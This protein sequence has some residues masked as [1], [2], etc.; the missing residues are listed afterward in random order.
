MQ[1]AFLV[2]WGTVLIGALLW[3]LAGPGEFALRDMVVLHDPYLTHSS[4]GFGDLPGRNVPQDAVLALLPPPATWT[5]RIMLIVS[6]AV[7]AFAA[8]RLAGPHVVAQAAAMTISVANPFVI[9]RLL[10]GHWSLVMAAWLL[11]AIAAAGQSKRTGW[12][13]IALWGASLTPTGGLAATATAFVTNRRPIVA[14]AGAVSC[15]PWI[16]TGMLHPDAGRSA[17][18]SAEAFAPRAEGLV[19]TLGALLGLG[20]LWNGDAVPP[21]RDAGFAIFGVVLFALLATAYRRIPASFLL[22]AA[23]GFGI[24]VFSWLAPGAMGWLIEHVP[25]AG[26]LRDGQ[27]WVMLAIPAYVAAA[28]ALSRRW[29]AIALVLAFLQTPDAPRAMSVLSPVEVSVPAVDHQGRD[30][31]FID[32][33]AL[34]QRTDGIPVVDPATKA[35][36]VVE[37]GGL[38]VDGVVLDEDSL[39]YQDGLDDPQA[40]GIG[41]IVHPDGTVE[42][43]GAPARPRDPAGIALLVLWAITP[44]L[45]LIGRASSDGPRRRR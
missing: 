4:L 1:R 38:R 35:M 44:L 32:R 19:G 42:D 30:V 11:P 28:G 3:P 15:S 25:G 10:Q 36:N 23:L 45:G 6:A 14:L 8:T 37:A 27:K 31:Y 26:L 20:G 7:S 5:V 41:L 17:A 29:A 2:A 12:Q 16:I 22:L 40:Y 39:R 21:S 43:T 18:A 33:P 24:A 13:I 9:E 34:I